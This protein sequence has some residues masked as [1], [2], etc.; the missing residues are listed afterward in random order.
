MYVLVICCHG[1]S[2]HLY[3]SASIFSMV[4]TSGCVW[5]EDFSRSSKACWDIILFRRVKLVQDSDPFFLH[6][7]GPEEQHP[8]H[9]FAE[10]HGDLVSSLG[11]VLDDQ[12]VERPKA[13]GNLVAALLSSGCCAAVMRL[14]HWADK[15]KEMW[16]S[17]IR[18]WTSQFVNADIKCDYTLMKA[19]LRCTPIFHWY[20]Q[21]QP[22]QN[23]NFKILLTSCSSLK[24]SFTGCKLIITAC[25][26]SAKMWHQSLKCLCFVWRVVTQTHHELQQHAAKIKK[27][28]LFI[29]KDLQ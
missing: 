12:V 4:A 11:S 20:S 22:N 28:L 5:P 26:V 2:P 3:T 27:V 16:W 13:G 23:T 1:N 19:V 21:Y 18:V 6:F 14:R 8:S 7:G 24:S 25:D 29:N 17:V 10:W 9:L 15:D